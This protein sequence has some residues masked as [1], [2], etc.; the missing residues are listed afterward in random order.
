MKMK[1][2]N[3]E[4]V[5]SKLQ[6]K[7]SLLQASLHSLEQVTPEISRVVVE[8]TTDIGNHVDRRMAIASLFKNELVAIP[9]SFREISGYRFTATGFVSAKK[10]ERE[11]TDEV[12][13]SGRYKAI[14]SN[15]M[16]DSED[17]SLWSVN[18]SGDSK[19]LIRH[20]EEDLSALVALA[21]LEQRSRTGR[22][23]SVSSIVTPPIQAG[24]Y[25]SYVN[26][27]TLEVSH[28]YSLGYE[29]VIATN[30][31]GE[32]EEFE[33]LQILDKEANDIINID[34]H[35]VVESA[36]MNG[37]D[38]ENMPEEILASMDEYSNSKEGMKEYYK[39]MFEYSPEYY[40]MMSR[41]I[42][43]HAVA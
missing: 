42:D 30:E 19:Y 20:G 9:N 27:M 10:E 26:P 16:M 2:L 23:I 31:D 38:K 43:G 8:F 21:S 13:A 28:G 11:Y 5:V 18:S 41:I 15:I 7:V 12:A 4:R 36:V 17:E 24:E 25:V 22:V 14:A 6:D 33:E 39:K 1:K 35:L 40:E 3:L 34:P 37:D 32:E 29:T